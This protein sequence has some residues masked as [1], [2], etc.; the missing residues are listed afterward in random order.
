MSI[1]NKWYPVSEQLPDLK[2]NEW[3]DCYESEPVL[4]YDNDKT[5]CVAHMSQCYSE[6]DEMTYPI[7]WYTNCS[8]RWDITKY[9]THWMPLPE[10]P[11]DN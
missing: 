8:E 10:G 11:C 2:L 7:R 6:P 9:V 4:V 5:K 3:N 1:E